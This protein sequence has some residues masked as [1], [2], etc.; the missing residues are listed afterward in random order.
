MGEGAPSR[1]KGGSLSLVMLHGRHAL[2][3]FADIKQCIHY[4]SRDNLLK[5]YTVQ[6]KI[7]LAPISTGGDPRGLCFLQVCGCC[8]KLYSTPRQVL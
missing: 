3:Y 5:A 7:S 4:T 1:G 6:M 8:W 2:L